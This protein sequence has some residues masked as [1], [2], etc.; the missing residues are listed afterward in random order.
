MVNPSPARRI[1][2]TLSH[3]IVVP[4][5]SRRTGAPCRAVQTRWLVVEIDGQVRLVGC[6][7]RKGRVFRTAV[8]DNVRLQTRSIANARELR[9]DDALVRVLDEAATP[10]FDM[11]ASVTLFDF[12]TL[13]LADGMDNYSAWPTVGGDVVA[14]LS[15]T[16]GMLVPSVDPLK[17]PFRPIGL[18]WE[19]GD[20]ARNSS[21][22]ILSFVNS[23]GV[24]L[25]AAYPDALAAR[26]VRRNAAAWTNWLPEAPDEKA[27]RSAARM[28]AAFPKREH[29]ALTLQYVLRFIGKHPGSEALSLKPG[30]ALDVVIWKNG[31]SRMGKRVSA[32]HMFLRPFFE[33]FMDPVPAESTRHF[34]GKPLRLRG[35]SAPKPF[36]C[37]VRASLALGGAAWMPGTGTGSTLMPVPSGL[38]RLPELPCGAPDERFCDGRLARR[39]LRPLSGAYPLFFDEFVSRAGLH[40]NL[41]RVIRAARDGLDDAAHLH[42]NACAACV[43]RLITHV[44]VRR[45]A[46][47]GR[48]RIDF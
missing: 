15:S 20:F 41:D 1:L 31:V 33:R 44:D 46:A 14:R 5:L 38:A 39:S 34:S 40:H 2:L 13:R 36:A 23:A 30:P 22:A 21:S 6:R 37:G 24:I 32:E 35:G 26:F 11:E 27:Q 25:A 16:H 29:I 7:D 43:D 17:P 42:C 47:F 48:Y 8:R 12:R 4:A 3:G 28:E 9:A 19:N 18:L 10:N 45:Q